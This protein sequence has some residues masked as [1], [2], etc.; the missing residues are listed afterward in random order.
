VCRRL[1][2]KLFHFLLPQQVPTQVVGK[3]SFNSDGLDPASAARGMELVVPHR[4]SLWSEKRALAWA[5]TAAVSSAV[6]GGTYGG[7]PAGRQAWTRYFRRLSI[8]WEKSSRAFDAYLQLT[9][10]FLPAR[11]VP[12]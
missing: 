6:G 1:A 11:Q 10:A 8:R 2:Q 4:S 12:G 3:K 7:L 5:V 9:C